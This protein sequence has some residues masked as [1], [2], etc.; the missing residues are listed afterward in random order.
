M[1]KKK[2][3]VV[4]DENTIRE[5]LA[6]FFESVKIGCD[7]AGNRQRALSLLSRNRYFLIFLDYNLG[8]EKAAETVGLIK[9]RCRAV[10]VV[11][12]TGSQDMDEG[13]VRDLG[14]ADLVFKPFRFETVMAV[15]NRYLENQ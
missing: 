7:V 15:V 1:K 6:D 4:D 3:L 14:V 11:L 5:M 10:P 13:E 8:R 2:I 12:M 9:N